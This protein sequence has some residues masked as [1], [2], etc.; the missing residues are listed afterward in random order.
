MY[1]KA[2]AGT[3]TKGTGKL[4]MYMW[5]LVTQTLTAV[6][7]K[8]EALLLRIPQCRVSVESKLSAVNQNNNKQTN[9]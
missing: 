7:W 6:R 3:Y 5:P 8:E 4:H 2:S 1:V 9:K